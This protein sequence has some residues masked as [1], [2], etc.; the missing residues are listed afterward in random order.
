MLDEMLHST[1]LPWQVILARL[2]LAVALG[3]I[4]GFERELADRPA[5]FRTHMLISLA[6]A[7]FTIITLEMLSMPAFEPDDVRFDPLRLVDAIT[8]GV[9]F[10]A[11]GII[12]MRHGEV[13][14]LTTGAGM[15]LAAAAGLAAG[16]GLWLIAVLASG[17]GA[18]I[19]AAVRR[20]ET[21]LSLKSPRE[22]CESD[23]GS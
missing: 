10:L 9:A 21:E 12:L 7:A 17:L 16:L 5:G 15:W 8:A 11:A 3:G 22:G 4:L 19:L 18:L 6:S 2:L 14:G 23:S 1:Q 13:K 20:L